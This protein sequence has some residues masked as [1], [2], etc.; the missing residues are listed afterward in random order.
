MIAQTCYLQDC[1]FHGKAGI[2]LDLCQYRTQLPFLPIYGFGVSRPV[3]FKY[4]PPSLIY[5]S[6]LKAI[7]TTK[8]R[9]Q[10]RGGNF[11]RTSIQISVA[12]CDIFY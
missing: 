11:A 2:K 9:Y 4:S 3:L 7:K 8:F 12:R 10:L 6:F 1:T 5:G